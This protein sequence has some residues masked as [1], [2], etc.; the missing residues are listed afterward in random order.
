M[1]VVDASCYAE[2]EAGVTLWGIKRC[3][4]PPWATT[5]CQPS[6]NGS[7]QPRDRLGHRSPYSSCHTPGCP[8]QGAEGC[9]PEERPA[10]LSGVLGTAAWST[11]DGVGEW[12]PPRTSLTT[13]SPRRDSKAGG[14]LGE[15]E[16]VLG[17]EN[18]PLLA[19]PQEETLMLQP[20]QTSGDCASHQHPT[21]APL[22]SG[23]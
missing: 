4:F 23:M 19:A 12:E 10:F 15:E 11:T 8:A 13:A 21:P 2:A 9:W 7:P 5:C 16:V 17:G 18:L 14:E 6:L 3:V 20:A 22:H 1:G